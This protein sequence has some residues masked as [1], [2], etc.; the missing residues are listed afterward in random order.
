M[1]LGLRNFA[2]RRRDISGTGSVGTRP[3]ASSG[4]T[5]WKLM[6]VLAAAI[7]PHIYLQ[8]AATLG[9]EESHFCGAAGF[10]A[11]DRRFKGGRISQ[12]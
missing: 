1:N 9:D 3:G 4:F 6:R 12:P 8:R 11:T 10:C 7:R 5:T 2:G